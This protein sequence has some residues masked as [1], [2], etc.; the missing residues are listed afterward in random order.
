MKAVKTLLTVFA[1]MCLFSTIALAEGNT[2]AAARDENGVTRKSRDGHLLTTFMSVTEGHFAKVLRELKLLSASEAARSG[3]WNAIK[4]RLTRLA[5]DHRMATA[6]FA[7]PDGSYYTVERDLTGQNLRDRPYFPRLMAGHDVVGDLATGKTT[8]KKSLIIATPVIR[9]GKVTGA[10]G[11]SLSSEEVSGMID[12]ELRLPR[13]MVFYALDQQGR[14]ALHRVTGL[15]F[16]FPSDA[17]SASLRQ[18]V[19]EMLAK[20]EGTLTYEYQG[21]KNVVFARSRL[22]GWTFVIGSASEKDALKAAEQYPPLLSDIKLEITGALG[23]MN[24]RLGAAA[25]NLSQT[26]PRDGNARGILRNLCLSEP[27]A[28]DCA[29][30]DP[31]GTMITMEPEEFRKFE[32]TSIG[33]QEQ[34][35]RVMT[36]KRPAMS[37]SFRSVEG[38]DAVDLEYPVFSPAGEFIGSASLL[39]RPESLLDKIIRP[40]TRGMPVD[41][42][43]MQPDGRILYDSD[44]EEIGRML[45]SDPLYKPFPQLLSLGKLIAEQREGSG[46]YRFPGKGMKEPVRK[47]AYWTTV[48]MHGAEW[49]IVLTHAETKEGAAVSR[50]LSGGEVQPYEVALRD[51]ANSDQVKEA[52]ARGDAG[53]IQPLFKQFYQRNP[54]IYSVQWVDTSGVNRYGFPE[55][56]SLINVDLA[57]RNLQSNLPVLKALARKREAAFD[58]P[59]VEGREGHFVMVPV[60]A[61]SAYLGMVYLIRINP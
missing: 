58:T 17:G 47:D 50:G 21:G 28:I 4:D 37:A 12:T 49:R 45:F 7:L 3:N 18:A 6:W 11:A 56:N 34:I 24:A 23:H 46:S 27:A 10:L 32:G 54:G 53:K 38:F 40:F 43:V 2:H 30:V 31:K 59:L 51:F 13:N 16:A 20:P 22:T 61:N 52:L 42:W 35:R 25:K 14:T 48:G 57:S 39:F 5:A 9:D 29:I 19:N 41:I 60:F 36:L 15:L 44:A 33:D 55:H 1:I 26:G 8:G